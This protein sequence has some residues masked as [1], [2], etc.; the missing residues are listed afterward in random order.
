MIK[1]IRSL[2]CL[3]PLLT[4]ICMNTASGEAAALGE[5]LYSFQVQ[6][7]EESIAL[8]CTFEQMKQAGW[9]YAGNEEELLKPEQ[10]TVSSVW[11]KNGVLLSGEMVNTSWDV[12]PVEECVLAA[13]ELTS[14]A[15]PVLLPGGVL[16]GDSGGREVVDAYGAPSSVYEDG[17]ISRYTYQLDYDREAVFTFSASTGVLKAASLRNV[18]MA[19]APDP[20]VLASSAASGSSS[21]NAPESLGDDLLSLRVSY[22]DA[23]YSLPA[24][25]KEFEKHG[26]VLGEGAGSVV[27]A[28]G[29][30]QLTLSLNGKRWTTWV[31]NN[32]D[33]AALA[34]SCLV[35]A[36]VSDV[37]RGDVSLVL[38][39][40]VTTGMAEEE[41]LNAY[42]SLNA[43]ISETDTC[44]RYAFSGGGAGI[45]LSVQKDSGLI[46][47]VEVKNVP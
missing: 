19:A 12:L 8:P 36:V 3:M 39:G 32:S 27:K 18:V 4:F 2:I 35:T 20:M 6:I 46:C 17:E 28:Y 37:K 45:V 38:P 44:R 15:S 22:G 5:D 30:G 10:R 1:A 43:K 24:P 40:G 31:Y 47:R 33:K 14:A 7:G 23:L 29:S 26:W 34:G 9:N 25:V 42:A 13:V 16:I 21:Y 41:A 11:E